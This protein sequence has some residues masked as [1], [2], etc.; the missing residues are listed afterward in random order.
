MRRSSCLAVLSVASLFSFSSCGGGTHPLACGGVSDACVAQ[1]HVYATTAANEVLVFPVSQTGTLGSPT[2]LPGPAITGGSIAVSRSSGELFVADHGLNTVS[3][4]V[5]GTDG[6]YSQVPGSPYTVG[7]PGLLGA[8]TV[9]P[10]GHFVYVVGEGGG[11]GGFSIAAN[12]SLTQVP[13]SPVSV[14]AQ[15]VDAVIDASGKFLF[16]ISGS[17]ISV[18]SINSSNGSL[19][20]AGAS[21]PL[22]SFTL[23][24]PGMAA[25]MGNFLF[26]ALG[27]GSVAAFSFDANSGMLTPVSGSPF[28]AGAGSLNVTATA[29]AVYI[30]N[31]MDGTLSAFTWDNTGVLTPISGSP[32][33][34]PW[35]AG[36]TSINGQYLYVASV[37]HVLSPFA[38]AILG[39]S[40]D[41]SGAITPL[42]GSPYQSGAP[43]WGGMAAF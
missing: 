29:K 40:I 31:A 33:S 28:P 21:V 42:P 2:S 15:S 30:T 5:I 4:F 43:L 1:R 8:V 13:G 3:A 36:L 11:I 39:Y 22:P 7:T 12:G 25:T 23:P 17:S 37:N 34:A 26:V 24:T 14:T 18:F 16:A 19:T 35:G 6:K 38:N 41:P 9:S 20:A 27:T 32:F 10:D